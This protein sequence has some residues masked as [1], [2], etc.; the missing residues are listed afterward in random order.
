VSFRRAVSWVYRR[1]V[2]MADAGRLRVR[3]EGRMYPAVDEDDVEAFLAGTIPP[4]LV[5]LRETAP[6]EYAAAGVEIG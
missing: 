4:S 2:A 3:W 5:R 6:M 1:L